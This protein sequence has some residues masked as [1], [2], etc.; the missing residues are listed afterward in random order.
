[1]NIDDVVNQYLELYQDIEDIKEER[2]DRME[3]FKKLEED[4]KSFLTKSRDKA[5]S[6]PNGPMISLKE[7]KTQKGLNPQT[8]EDLLT[9]FFNGDK[10]KSQQI[11]AFLWENRVSDTK[12][13]VKINK[14]R[15]KVAKK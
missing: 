13:V 7:K 4:I 8:I 10:A 9:K 14:P 3:I 6:T 1:M 2:K 12:V 11:A 5:I 15:K